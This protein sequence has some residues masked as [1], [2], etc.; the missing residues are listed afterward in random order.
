M[1]RS[2]NHGRV[3]FKTYNMDQ[4]SLPLSLDCLIAP[5]HPV[6]VVNQVIEEMKLEPLL[7]KYKG[8]GTSSYH[9]KMMLK[10]LVYGYSQKLFSSRK[11]ARAICENIPFM[12]LAGGNQ[13]DFHTINRFRAEMQPIIEQVFQELMLYMVKNGIINLR[14]LFVDGTK[15]EANANK[16]TFVWG[17]GLKRQRE[18]LIQTI[19]KLLEEIDQANELE[20][21][22][23][24]DEDLT[25]VSR[26]LVDDPEGL[27]ELVKRVDDAV[28]GKSKSPRDKRVRV[29]RKVARKLTKDCLPRAQRYKQQI[30]E[31]GEQRHSMSKTDKDATFMR[32][33]EDHMKNGQLKPGYNVQIGTQGQFVLNFSVH[34]HPG[35]TRCLKD[36]L[37]Q[38]RATFGCYPHRLIADAGYGSEENLE[39]LKGLDIFPYVKYSMFHQEQKAHFKNDPYRKE[40]MPYDPEKDEYT[41]PAGRKLTYRYT[42]K[43][44]SE[45]GY[46]S[47]I[48]YYECESCVDCPLREACTK[49]KDGNRGIGV[50]R[51]LEELKAEARTRLLSRAGLVARKKRCVEPE[52]VFG[53]IKWCWGFKRFLLRGLEKVKTEWG[54]LCIAHNLMKMA[55]LAR[56]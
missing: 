17:K 10:V 47:H 44:K 28:A 26:Q 45:A 23:Y 32:M 54:I 7:A 13:P 39:Y 3:I 50:N 8:G 56:A 11:I 29:T 19:K 6:R 15:M 2:R 35:D 55:A 52:A 36:H 5:N 33:K 21:K 24:G 49:S 34:Q 4:L 1:R 20:E 51:R 25:E 18:Q 41:C 37:E 38:F 14:S 30:E 22:L 53:R 42:S 40:T 43:R 48:R 46:T 27:A 31:I 9:P 16:Y 12:W